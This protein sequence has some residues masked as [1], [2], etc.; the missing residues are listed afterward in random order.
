MVM[1][2]HSFKNVNTSVKIHVIYL[3]DRVS[4]VEITI[5]QHSLDICAIV[6]KCKVCYVVSLSALYVVAGLNKIVS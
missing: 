4:A 3:G 1:I 2:T 5:L 6:I